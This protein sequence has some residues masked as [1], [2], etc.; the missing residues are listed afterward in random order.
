[1]TKTW[2]LV[3][4]FL[5]V[6]S[7]FSCIHFKCCAIIT[8]P[9]IVSGTGIVFDRFLSLFLCFFVYFFVSKISRK[10]LDRFVWNFQGR[11]GVTMGRPDYIFGQFRETARSRNT[12][13]GFVMLRTTACLLSNW[14]WTI[15]T[16]Y[17]TVYWIFKQIGILFSSFIVN[18]PIGLCRR[19]SK[20]RQ[21]LSVTG[22]TFL[23]AS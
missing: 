9:P 11:C 3:Y 4:Y 19:L 22:Y 16:D 1:M 7:L 17:W 15:F 5:T 14:L 12:G 10:R 13:A 21:F 23:T 20:T 8:P 6:L 18:F 2:W